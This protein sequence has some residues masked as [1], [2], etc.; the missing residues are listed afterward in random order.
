MISLSNTKR[1][2]ASAATGLLAVLVGCAAPPQATNL[3][4]ELPFEQAVAQATDGLAAQT[5]KMP[6]FLAK[7]EQLNKRPV[8]LDPM[9]DAV[10]GQ[11]T[12]ATVLLESRVSERLT[13]SKATPFEILPFQSANLAKAQFLLTGTMTRVEGAAANRK[14]ALQ[15]NL[16]LTDLKSGTVVAQASALA[17]DEGLDHTPL[18]YYRDSPI[19]VKDKVIE[20]YARTSAT[21]PGQRGDAFYLERIA[22]A[23]LINE[24]TM[25]YNQERYVEA[26]GQY[27]SALATPTG[28]QLRVLN[29][30]Y[31]TTAK[32]GRTA[33][34]E[35]AFGR[36]VALGIA[37]NELGVKFLF[38][39][40]STD[41]WSDTKVSGPYGMWLRQIAKEGTAAKVCMNV[42]GH[43]SK[44]G[45][46]QV[47]DTLSL[48][49][50]NAIR[51]KLSAE[52]AVLGTRTKTVGMGFRQN[53]VGSGTDNAVDALDRR[54]EFKIT[55]C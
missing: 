29:G 44:T 45:S 3:N 6:A 48:A 2:L 17:R 22:S 4:E 36:V 7:V 28:E 20:G 41:F 52:S 21:P 27:R 10:T 49:R 55:P 16:A 43:T 31:L 38:N 18:A 25:L 11:Q 14:R 24:A 39:P 51:Q 12:A 37:Y 19:L 33:E 8:V 53:I 30:I 54:V 46:E 40:G 26:L 47:N 1:L 32:L 5:Q 50:A 23:T 34:A 15:I 13:T 35:Q 42:V 9:L